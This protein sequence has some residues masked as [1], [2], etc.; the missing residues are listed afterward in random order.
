VFPSV[1]IKRDLIYN[2]FA[3]LSGENHVDIPLVQ[4]THKANARLIAAAPA[5]LKTL[6]AMVANANWDKVPQNE[7]E[8]DAMIV[9]AE[10]AIR[11][12]KEGK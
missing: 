1:V 8:F 12:A 5:L 11:L 7:A 6:E 10:A 9:R 4:R 3:E 2:H